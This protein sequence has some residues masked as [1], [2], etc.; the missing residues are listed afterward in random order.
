M[1]SRLQ[2]CLS[3]FSSTMTEEEITNQ[4]VIC[5]N[6]ESVTDCLNGGFYWRTVLRRTRPSARRW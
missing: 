1:D 2:T 3:K 6:C 4:Y 5:E